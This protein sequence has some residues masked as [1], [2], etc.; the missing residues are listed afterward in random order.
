MSHRKIFL[1]YGDYVRLKNIEKKYE[2]LLKK[3]EK[4]EKQHNEVMNQWRGQQGAGDLQDRVKIPILQTTESI[5][6]PANAFIPKKQKN[7]KEE[8]PAWYYL[9]HPSNFAKK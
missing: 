1:D 7:I 2:D 3:H 6:V 8:K 5:T 9:G 4:L